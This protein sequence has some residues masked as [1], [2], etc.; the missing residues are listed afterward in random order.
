LI[1]RTTPEIH[2]RIE[3]LKD[4]IDVPVE[5]TQTPIRFYKLKN[6]N[7]LD[8]LYTILSLQEVSGQSN[9]FGGAPVGTGVTIQNEFAPGMSSPTRAGAA[10][11][12]GTQLPGGMGAV[13]SARTRRGIDFPE[14]QLEPFRL[15]V[16]PEEELQRPIDSMQQARADRLSTVSP[17]AGFGPSASLPGGARAAADPTTNSIVVAAPIEAQEMYKKLI[18][19]LDV[20][21][22]QVLIDAKIVAVDTTDDFTLGVEISGGD[23]EGAS[24]LFGFSS[25]GL[26]QVDPVTG[27]LQ[28][29]PMRGF[30]GTLVNPEVAD[31]VVQALATHTRARVLASPRILVNDNAT[32]QLESVSSVPF[33]SIN[34]VNTIQTQSLGGSQQ[35]GTLITVTPHI[36]EDDHLLLEFSVEFSTFSGDGT[37]TLPPPRQIDRVGSTVTVPDGQTVIVGGLKRDGETYSVQGIPYLEKIPL[38]RDLS[39][40]KSNGLT[41]TSFFL[42]IRPIILRDDKFKDLKHLSARNARIAEIGG[43]YPASRPILVE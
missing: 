9:I 21:R 2:T 20:R 17:Q 10:R 14:N 13:P 7:A 28:I 8:V 5:A 16:T 39:T 32:G 34:V 40:I 36:S 31:V 30:N 4:Q 18:E 24:R 26:S 19:S 41:S 1:V 42:F 37:Q 11:P 35:A 43:D 23:R 38:I 33:E 6:A 25:F 29:I 15:P 22:P 12:D 3:E 27:A